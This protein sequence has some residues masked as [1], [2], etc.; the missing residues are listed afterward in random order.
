[1]QEGVRLVLYF[2]EW[3]AAGQPWK[4]GG[5]VAERATGA[6]GF[7]QGKFGVGDHTNLEVVLPV[8][9]RLELRWRDNS[10]AGAETWK[11][12]GVVTYGAGIVNAVAIRHAAAYSIKW[13]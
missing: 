3:N 11:P 1:M 6:P 10:P 2:R 12:G 9:D 7:I 5:V 4:F 13:I 8:D